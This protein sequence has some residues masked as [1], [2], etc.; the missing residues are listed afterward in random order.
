MKYLL[1]FSLVL[2]G[3]ST[4]ASHRSLK[5]SGGGAA[6]GA[7]LG[8]GFSPNKESQGLNALLWGG[9]GAAFGYLFER[10]F[11]DRGDVVEIPSNLEAKEL[12]RES[13]E[14]VLPATKQKLPAFVQKR[15]TPVVIEQYTEKD[16][17]GE[18]GSL[19]EPHRVWRIKQQPELLP[20]PLKS[21]SPHK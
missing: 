19:H 17:A 18:D 4:F 10:A 16:T 12:F 14:F 6:A 11:R 5:Y 20:K 3:C 15:L 7:A 8:Y 9:I 2:S 21:P 1:I 13:E